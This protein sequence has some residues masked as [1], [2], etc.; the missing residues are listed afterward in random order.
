V[1][2]D[3]LRV[4]VQAVPMGPLGSSVVH[5]VEV[6]VATAE[7][8]MGTWVYKMHNTVVH[9]TRYHIRVVVVVDRGQ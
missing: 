9:N 2:V 6:V 4:V 5:P 1:K 3:T 8:I 7:T